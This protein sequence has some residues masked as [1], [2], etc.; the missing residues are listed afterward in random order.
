MRDFRGGLWK[1]LE[2]L[3]PPEESLTESPRR[4]CRL[5]LLQV[6]GKVFPEGTQVFKKRRTLNGCELL[7]RAGDPGKLQKA[8]LVGSSGGFGETSAKP[9]GHWGP[10]DDLGSSS[11]P[12]G[13]H[14]GIPKV[15]GGASGGTLGG[16]RMILKDSPES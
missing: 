11:R 15:L 9:C 7:R 16:S 1:A 10:L 2:A 5:S 6:G 8:D 4:P 14:L 3:G 13:R 12:F